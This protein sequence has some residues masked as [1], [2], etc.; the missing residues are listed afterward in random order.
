MP[1]IFAG[2]GFTQNVNSE[3]TVPVHPALIERGFL[4]FAKAVGSGPLFADLPPNQFGSRGGN[5]NQSSGALGPIAGSYR[6]PDF[7]QPLLA[8]SFEDAWSPVCARA[9]HCGRYYRASSQDRG[10]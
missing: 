2:G 10:G 3:R 6:S 8:P 9:R 4:Q 7:A 5:R 1:S